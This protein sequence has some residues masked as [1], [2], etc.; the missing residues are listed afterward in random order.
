ME[1]LSCVHIEHGLR[2]QESL[3]DAA[4]V[5]ALCHKL[6]VRCMVHHIPGGEIEQAAARKKNGVEAE[7]RERRHTLLA[8][9]AARVGASF[10]VIAHTQNDLLELFLMRVLR[11]SGPGGLAALP[12]IAP[13]PYPSAALAGVSLLRPFLGVS[14]AEILAYLSEKGLSYR[15]D[16]TNN[17]P[18]FLRNR[19]R[20][21]LMPVLDANFPS[22][23]KSA[24]EAAAIQRE[25][26]AFIG[27]EAVARLPFAAKPG[28]GARSFNQ[29][30]TVSE[31]VAVFFAQALIIREEALF[32]ALDRLAPGL[33][34]R[35]EA[36]R[37]FC[38]GEVR[39]VNLGGGNTL[40]ARGSL[41]KLTI[42]RACFLPT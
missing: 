35:R 20:L 18:R 8:R 25:T 17:D 38:A 1:A 11:G 31:P 5:E 21:R 6:A 40:D 13:L 16:S 27:H 28:Q 32:Q 19:V 42:R 29:Y 14:R 4:F 24:G 39:F 36:L 10:V 9:E 2:G 22:W 33:I 3:D 30:V 23:R 12:E 41:I 37:Q 15:T 34:P 7:A 26:A